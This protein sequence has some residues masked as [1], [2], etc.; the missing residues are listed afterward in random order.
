MMNDSRI[1]L[2]DLFIVHIFVVFFGGGPY[3]YFDDKEGP[4]EMH[5]VQDKS[6]SEQIVILKR[7][8]LPIVSR[9]RSVHIHVG[10]QA[11]GENDNSHPYPG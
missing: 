7:D 5:S 11:E 6:H 10:E 2:F 9:R 4:K 3:S 1:S 8:H